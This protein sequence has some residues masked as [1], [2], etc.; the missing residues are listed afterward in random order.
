MHKRVVVGIAGTAQ[1]RT[2]LDWAL[3]RA[4]SRGEPVAAVYVADPALAQGR[5]TVAAADR[6]HGSVVLAREAFHVGAKAP[7]IEFGTEV[8]AGRPVDQLLLESGVADLIVVGSHARE[9][10]TRFLRRSPA[11]ELAGRAHCPIA[12]IPAFRPGRRG[13]IVGTDGSSEASAALQ[14]AADEAVTL[15]EPLTIVNVWSVTEVWVP[16]FVP[17]GPYYQHLIDAAREIV[18]AAAERM[19]ESHPTLEV[20]TVVTDGAPAATLARL[21][22]EAS[23]LIVGTRGRHGLAE[24]FLGSTSHELLV[25]PPCPVIVVPPDQLRTLS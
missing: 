3:H 24:F 11:I 8:R 19:R 14:F 23:E 2:A 7:H 21:S 10:G 22:R 13:V 12:V 17:D 18:D 9:G 6:T 20:D 25:E 15:G 1:S 5:Q 16:G 4:E